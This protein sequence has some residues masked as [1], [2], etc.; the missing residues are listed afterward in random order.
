MGSWLD[1]GARYEIAIDWI[2]EVLDWDEQEMQY[3]LPNSF[4]ADGKLILEA[5]ARDPWKRKPEDIGDRV[6]DEEGA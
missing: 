5:D 4:R 1:R 6:F 2:R 3:M